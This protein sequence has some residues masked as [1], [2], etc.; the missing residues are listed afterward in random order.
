MYC[1]TTPRGWQMWTTLRGKV[2]AGVDAVAVQAAALGVEP[3]VASM[4]GG[5]GI[6]TRT[7]GP[8]DPPP[9]KTYA[10][11]VELHKTRDAAGA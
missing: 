11:Y 10:Q 6:P 4:I 9:R 1:L 7:F 8:G 2:R 3:A 5:A